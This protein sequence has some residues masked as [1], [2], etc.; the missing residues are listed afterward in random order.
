MFFKKTKI[1]EAQIDEF[2]D[3]MGN[4][5]IVFNTGVND[6]LTGNQEKFAQRLEQITKFE[7]V[8]DKTR[9]KIEN[10][11]YS[12]S[13]LPEHRGDVLGLLESLDK[14]IDKA[15][16]ILMQFDVEALEIPPE[17]NDLF[18]QL[19]EASMNSAEAIV[20][21]ARSFF[22]DYN[23]VKNY[24]HKVYFYEKEADKLC[25]ELKRKIFSSNLEYSHK[26]AFTSFCSIH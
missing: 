8:A 13:L 26:L 22:K 3:A 12:H 19:S 16:E 7:G 14:V 21:S 2:L 10:Q 6:Y 15:K 23:Q 5:M 24:L 11:L 25:S 1:L 4:G 17:Y 20:H 9:R 18:S